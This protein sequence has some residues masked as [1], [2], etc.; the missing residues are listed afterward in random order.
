[1]WYFLAFDTPAEHPRITSDELQYIEDNCL[2]EVKDCEGSKTPWK[3]IFLSMPA[4]AIGITTF[5]RIW[6]HYTFIM[7]G[8][9]YMKTMLGVNIQQNGLLSGIP[10]ICSYLSSVVFW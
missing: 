6:V 5:G 2:A 9:M 7:H 8:P 1:M 3:S 4:W 10:F